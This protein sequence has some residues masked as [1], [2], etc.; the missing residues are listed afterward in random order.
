MSFRASSFAPRDRI[1]GYII[2]HGPAPS[3]ASGLRPS[4]LPTPVSPGVHTCARNLGVRVFSPLLPPSFA[5]TSYFCYRLTSFVSA[6]M[7]FPYSYTFIQCTCFHSC[8]SNQFPRILCVGRQSGDLQRRL[9]CV[10][11]G[12]RNPVLF[13]P[14]TFQYS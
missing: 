8:T 10:T 11:T 3:P 5:R 13:H 12:A 14:P 2:D 4:G 1:S 7:P 6:S 9:V